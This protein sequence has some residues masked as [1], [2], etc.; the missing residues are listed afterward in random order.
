M[1]IGEL[2]RAAD[3]NV[4]T[5]RYYERR[6]IL[7]KPRRSSSGYRLYG[8]PTVQ[9]LV[10]IRRAQALGFTLAEVAGLLELHDGAGTCAEARQAGLDKLDDIDTKITRLTKM[11]SALVVLVE[12]CNVDQ[13]E[14]ALLE[15]LNGEEPPN[16]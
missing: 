7:P 9:R 3:V 8:P 2:A 14:C 16:E 15:A 10:F 5:V 6:G 11:R 12:S 1:R 4:E 13:R